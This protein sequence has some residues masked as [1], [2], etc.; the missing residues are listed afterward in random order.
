MHRR[1]FLAACFALP[2]VACKEERAEA[3][4][5]PRPVTAAAIGTFCGMSLDEHPGPKGQIFVRDRADPY[6]FSTVRDAIAFTMLPEMPRDI[7]A[8]YVSDMARARD[9]DQPET[10]V[11]AQQAL[12]VIGSRRRSGMQTDEAIPFGEAAAA[13]RFAAENGGQV[14]RF[15]EIPPAYIF[16]DGER[17]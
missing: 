3:P 13:H 6:W 11:T 2:V 10:W 12:F 1:R 7:A 15:S 16:P 5:P 17:S 4:P 8:I 14:L 9:W